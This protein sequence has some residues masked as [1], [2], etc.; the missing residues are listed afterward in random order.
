[1][2]IAAIIENE[3]IWQVNYAYGHYYSLTEHWVVHE[4]MV[5]FKVR[6]IFK[7]CIPKKQMDWD[8]HQQAI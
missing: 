3:N 1:M 6:N 4:I 7:K 2:K 8:K 5:L